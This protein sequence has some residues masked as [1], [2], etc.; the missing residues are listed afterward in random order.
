MVECFIDKY[1]M[2]LRK[3]ISY[4]EMQLE[5]KW[6][7]HSELRYQLIIQPIIQPQTPVYTLIYMPPPK[8]PLSMHH[9]VHF[10]QL[11]PCAWGMLID[12]L[13]DMSPA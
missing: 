1:G 3:L 7:S 13:Q 5:K 4:Y 9:L 8:T 11:K 10:N 12:S 2:W 6:V